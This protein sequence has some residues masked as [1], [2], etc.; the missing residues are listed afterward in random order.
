MSKQQ[1]RVIRVAIGYEIYKYD[2]Y[3]NVQIV[4]FSY[5]I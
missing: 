4:F 2:N 1:N 5:A 3:F